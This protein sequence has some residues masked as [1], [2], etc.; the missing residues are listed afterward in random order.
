MKRK[1]T[2]LAALLA[3]T[4]LGVSAQEN[5]NRDE[6]NKIVRGPYE[7][8]GFFDNIFIGVAGGINVYEGDFD[9]HGSDRIGGAL[10]INIGKWITPSVGARIGW[11]GVT[12]KGYTG[13]QSMY[14]AGK[15]AGNAF[16]EKFGVS[17]LHID[18]MWNL[19]HAI[20]G[21]KETRT[22]NFILF[23]GLGWARSFSWDGGS[24][25]D[26]EPAGSI[27][28]LN[29]IRLGKVVDLTLE[30][31]QL[32]VADRFDGVISGCRGEG[33]TSVTAGLAFKFNRSNFSRA[34]A[35]VVPDYSTYLN[36]I[37]KLKA[38]NEE[39]RN[40][41]PQTETVTVTNTVE[42]HEPT[43]V[44]LFFPIG[45]ATLDSKELTNLDFY[46]KHAISTNSTKT[47]TI[48]GSADKATGTAQINKEL[49][50]KRMQ[51]VYDI[52]VNKYNIPANRLVKKAVGDEN[53]RFDDPALN[54]CVFIE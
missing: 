29:T 43:P 45:K 22:W 35:P 31:R 15:A 23:G 27:G 25:R 42:T 37:E 2:L 38:E 46:V 32:F 16:K 9:S 7:T 53:N 39:L 26:N 30:V 28:L 21:Y 14:A 5:G 33:M 1:L 24:A 13:Y 19:S 17:Y 51:Y 34:K 50:E 10:D 36:E 40:R 48:T 20:G 54:R 11:S 12:A 8:N 41:K 18:A 44:V 47:F 3:F 6:N 52:L 4:V 49:S